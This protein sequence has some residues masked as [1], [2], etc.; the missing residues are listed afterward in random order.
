LLYQK[1]I[2]NSLTVVGRVEPFYDFGYKQVELCFSF[3][4]SYRFEKAL[5][6]LTK[7]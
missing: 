5:G 1:E 3:Y 6:K 4:L 2:I 7:E